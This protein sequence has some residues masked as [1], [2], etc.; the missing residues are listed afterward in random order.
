MAKRWLVALLVVF[1]C[2]DAPQAPPIPAAAL[3]I[4]SGAGDTS[5]DIP[6]VLVGTSGMADLVLRNAGGQRTGVLTAELDSQVPFAIDAAHSDCVG[7]ALEPAASCHLVLSFHPT[8]AGA[9]SANLT[10]LANP[11]GVFHILVSGRALAGSNLVALPSELDFGTVAGDQPA[12]LAITVTNVGSDTL[13]MPSPML[14]GPFAVTST[15]C[16]GS[17]AAGAQCQVI[18]RTAPTALGMATGAFTLANA[19]GESVPLRATIGGRITV[20]R[21]GEGS[22]QVTADHG[23]DCGSTC[24]GIFTAPVALAASAA[25]GSHVGWSVPSCTGTTC[26]LVP[27]LAAQVVTAT[28]AA[29]P[30]PRV[31]LVLDGPALGTVRIH[32]GDVVTTCSHTCSIPAPIGESVLLETDT[33][34]RFAGFTGACR[35]TGPRCAFTPG[36]GTA[37]IARFD[38]DPRERYSLLFASEV[39]SVDYDSMGDLVVGTAAE[40]IKLDPDGNERWRRP[41]GGV[42]RAGASDVIFVRSATELIKLDPHGTL[43]WTAPVA[44]GPRG[45]TSTMARSWAAMPD[46][47]VAIQ[48]PSALVVYNGADGSVRFTS[49]PIAG[50]RG[51]VAVDDTGLIFTAVEGLAADPTDLRV[52]DASGAEQARRE[53]VTPQYHAAIASA[54]NR[55]VYSSSGHSNVHVGS[56][57]AD[58]P[59]E[60]VDDPAFVENAAAIDRA[61]YFASAFALD[62]LGGVVL[63]HFAPDGHLQWRL[64]KTVASD[65]SI[66]TG[67]TAVDL[68]LDSRFGDLAVGGRYRSPTFSGGWVEVFAQTRVT[69]PPAYGSFG[70]FLTNEDL[71]FPLP[72]LHHAT[73]TMSADPDVTVHFAHTAGASGAMQ[74]FGEYDLGLGFLARVPAGDLRLTGFTDGVSAASGAT[75]YVVDGGERFFQVC[76]MS[77]TDAGGG[78]D[79][80]FPFDQVI[81]APSYTHA[82][83]FSEEH[84]APS[85][86][87]FHHHAYEFEQPMRLELSVPL[88][89][90]AIT[91]SR[92]A[93]VVSV[94]RAD[95]AATGDPS[96][97]ELYCGPPGQMAI[98]DLV[99]GRYYLIF[100]GIG[101]SQA[102]GTSSEAPLAQDF[103]FTLSGTAATGVACTDPLF[104][105][106]VLHCARGC[107]A[108]VCQ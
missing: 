88:E 70:W 47:G 93:P 53:N 34:S 10:L 106:G 43:V 18:V 5:V 60:R 40:V 13:P 19:I 41:F 2:G 6:G 91:A 21:D 37:V 87:P 79:C 89:G 82:G 78:H 46:G 24:T 22:G 44:G 55:L 35:S 33:P 38:R 104:A 8:V 52:F 27:T 101:D 36:D 20:I 71:V 54:G 4:E 94:Y 3:V 76:G 9:H 74:A 39:R 28:F 108:G 42:A 17:I 62:G 29:D 86:D 65:A 49:E 103:S 66:P 99:P 31:R 77:T 58:A 32:V 23:V 84:H 85:C 57:Q 67:V 97:P 72:A 45:E 90:L 15:T 25:A 75:Y 12:E 11:G 14:S 69:P 63:R 102:H 48:G 80:V 26:D 50:C 16:A 30:G 105:A 95:G 96:M 61:G 64:A 81:S 73:I 68:D 92:G 59:S 100:D 7:R 56:S 51:T 1:A 98:S 107:S 83:A